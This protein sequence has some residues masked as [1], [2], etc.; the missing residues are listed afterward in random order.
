MMSRSHTKS[1]YFYVI[2]VPHVQ[3]VSLAQR[4]KDGESVVRIDSPFGCGNRLTM[5]DDE[6]GR[7]FDANSGFE[8]MDTSSPEYDTS[9]DVCTS[10][11]KEY[12]MYE[13][14]MEQRYATKPFLS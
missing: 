6:D 3:F 5:D 7:I 8:V 14:K 12:Y 4:L 10:E 2:G 9:H 11:G 1:P 13:R